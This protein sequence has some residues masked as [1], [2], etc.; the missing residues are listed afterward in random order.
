V[1]RK[2]GI[3]IQEPPMSAEAMYRVLRI[4]KSIDVKARYDPDPRNDERFVSI[5]QKMI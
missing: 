3:V 2:E 4:V 1:E 5:L